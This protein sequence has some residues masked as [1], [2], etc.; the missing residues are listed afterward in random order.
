M[1]IQ[2]YHSV[3]QEHHCKPQKQAKKIKFFTTC[4]LSYMCPLL[5][6]CMLWN[7]QVEWCNSV[8]M[9]V[10]SLTSLMYTYRVEK[11]VYLSF[12]ALWYNTMLKFDM[13]P[14]MWSSSTLSQYTDQISI[15]RV[16]LWLQPFST[17][18]A[19]ADLALPA[20]LV[21][22]TQCATMLSALLG[23]TL[24]TQSGLIN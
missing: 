23:T 21:P 7:I 13:C 17:E 15:E 19:L 4:S 18:V 14:W 16:S 10:W 20:S 3:R 12:I 6:D 11:L 2:N 1:C 9:G 22:T 5:G 24:S 8:H